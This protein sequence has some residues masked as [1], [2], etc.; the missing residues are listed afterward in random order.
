VA[1]GAKDGQKPPIGGIV[2]E[3][4]NIEQAVGTAAV[5]AAMAGGF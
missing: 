1:A 4:G 3:V 2:G 5:L